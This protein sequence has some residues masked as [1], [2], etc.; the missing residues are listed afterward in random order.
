VVSFT[1]IP[2]IFLSDARQQSIEVIK[3][4][5]RRDLISHVR[6]SGVSSCEQLAAGITHDGTMAVIAESLA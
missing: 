3:L 5:P 1:V 2:R 6:R 4:Q